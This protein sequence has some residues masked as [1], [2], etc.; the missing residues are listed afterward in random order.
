MSS[1]DSGRAGRA[2]ELDR[3]DLGVVGAAPLR[4]RSGCGEVLARVDPELRAPTSTSESG[5]SVAQLRGAD[6][7]MPSRRI[8]SATVSEIT[9]PASSTE[10]IRSPRR[11]RALRHLRERS[12]VDQ[13]AIEAQSAAIDRAFSAGRCLL[14]DTDADAERLSTSAS[15]HN[16]TPVLS[17]RSSVGYAASA[18]ASR[19]KSQL[20]T[21]ASSSSACSVLQLS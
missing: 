20:A 21:R 10:A 9:A 13:A 16:V 15:G 14:A 5:E 18:S 3:S 4:S 6:L 11:R 1:P 12:P 19:S 2:E 17:S 7:A 8:E